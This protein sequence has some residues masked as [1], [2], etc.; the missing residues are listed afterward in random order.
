MFRWDFGP[1][2]RRSSRSARLQSVS[3]SLVSVSLLGAFSSLI[4][5][6]DATHDPNDF[7][8]LE[9]NF[10]GV[11]WND[12]HGT[13]SINVFAVGKQ[14]LG[15]IVARRTASGWSAQT[16]PSSSMLSVSDAGLS[17]IWVGGTTVAWAT[18]SGQ[19]LQGAGSSTV[20]NTRVVQFDGAIWTL[21]DAGSFTR[22]ARVNR[23]WGESILSVYLGWLETTTGSTTRVGFQR[24]S[25]L[26]PFSTVCSQSNAGLL[27]I[28]VSAMGP[29]QLTSVQVLWVLGPDTSRMVEATAGCP[30]GALSGQS[31]IA[32]Q[33]NEWLVGA[34]GGIVT[35]SST[36]EGLVGFT[37]VPSPTN[38][39]L[40]AIWGVATNDI[41]AVGDG[42]TFIHYNGAAWTTEPTITGNDLTGV[43][44]STATE[45]WVTSRVGEIFKLQVNPG[46]TFPYDMV[47][48]HNEHELSV[49]ASQA[50]CLGDEVVVH[51]D[52]DDQPGGVSEHLLELYVIDEA[53][54]MMTV[55]FVTLYYDTTTMK[56]T[57][58][59]TT[60]HSHYIAFTVPAGDYVAYAIGDFTGVGSVDYVDGEAFNVPANTCFGAEG[61]LGAIN[62]HDSNM[63]E[64]HDHQ[65]LFHGGNGTGAFD[66]QFLTLDPLESWT[67]LFFL[68]VMFMG[69]WNG[70]APLA[71]A[72]LLSFPMVFFPQ[73]GTYPISF[74]GAILLIVISLWIQY[75]GGAFFAMRNRRELTA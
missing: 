63:D 60:G 3:F 38:R 22:G 66:V 17:Q 16:V 24:G 33:W 56:R 27:E 19:W 14:G 51:V 67:L 72:A 47:R 15:P 2:V 28:E 73:D 20:V 12:I 32:D 9:A 39:N 70:W 69:L 52:M 7:F 5:G 36:S 54:S 18:F 43:Y 41:W 1:S 57:G 49:T 42:G 4:P 10:P 31:R 62:E 8:A 58:P 71:A 40:N 44:C 55:P 59:S 64:Q 25:H 26:S 23:I 48:Q 21:V 34:A 53:Q 45:C 65:D 35:V 11:I 75:L 13:S 37:S 29:D 61:I 68:L 46:V 30:S 6:A 50:Q 74:P